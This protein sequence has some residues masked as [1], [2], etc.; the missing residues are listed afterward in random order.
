M[1]FPTAS[2]MSAKFS[3]SFLLLE[4]VGISHTKEKHESKQVNLFSVGS[5]GRYPH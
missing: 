3:S 2:P 1:G 4:A 5:V